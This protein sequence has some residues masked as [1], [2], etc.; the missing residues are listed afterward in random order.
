[1]A[2]FR[3]E[4]ADVPT[5]DLES[6]NWMSALGDAL[7][8][9]E[10]G[11]LAGVECDVQ[12]NGDIHV[13]APDG[14]FVIREVAEA[15]ARVTLGGAA[16]AS[17]RHTS[18]RLG[19]LPLDVPAV[20]PDASG[21]DAPDPST[22]PAYRAKEDNADE[23]IFEVQDL[24]TALLDSE[25]AEAVCEQG[26][27]ILMKFIPAE[28]GAVLIRDRGGPDLRFTAARGPRSRGLVGLPV[29][30]GKGIAGLTV[31]ASIALI[32]REA[33]Q[34]PRHYG[35]V[36]QRT[37]YRTHG[38]LSVPVRGARGCVGCIQLLNP[39]AGTQFLPWHQTA[40]QIVAARIAERLA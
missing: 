38:I 33:T 12:P 8:R 21:Y 16:P 20:E 4:G 5:V 6:E 3:I 11:D 34:D 30:S 14:R 36:D 17:L 23:I 2:R 35:E 28:S 13:S 19:T 24:A 29:P 26:L 40:T 32:I 25:T 15:P 9:L 22:A 10:M 37:G 39:F 18:L 1:M 31:R 27:D 7:S